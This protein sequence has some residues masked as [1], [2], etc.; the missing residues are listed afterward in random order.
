MMAEN[1]LNLGREMDIQIQ[2][3]QRT[4]NRLNPNRAKMK[5]IVKSQRQKKDSKGS[6][7]KK[8]V[9]YK[10]T[11][12]TLQAD[13]SK[14]TFQSR[15]EWEYL[16]K[17]LKEKDCQLEILYPVKKSFRYKGGIKTFLRKLKLKEFVT[18]LLALR[19]MM[20]GVV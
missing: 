16:F 6:K 12:I 1:F 18:S 2:E 8:K 11:P 13:V 3:A 9:T 10:G 7:I 4:P 14:E 20:K 17:I 19:E 15:R 5:H